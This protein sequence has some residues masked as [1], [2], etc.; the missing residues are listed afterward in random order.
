[1]L[2]SNMRKYVKCL[3]FSKGDKIIY[4][5]I[6]TGYVVSGF[7]KGLL[8]EFYPITTESKNWKRWVTHIVPFTCPHCFSQNGKIYPV[9]Y[10]TGIPVHQN[11]HCETVR[12]IAIEAGTATKD[13]ENGADYWLKHYGKLPD[14]YVDRDV[15]LDAGWRKGKS[16]VKWFPGKMMYG[17]VF[18][19]SS[20]RL[21]NSPGRIWYE[22][23]INYYEGRRNQHRIYYSNDGLIFVTYDHGLTLYEII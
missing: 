11:C 13:G 14:Y 16:P 18:Y 19:N 2:I 21:P 7:I 15:Y 3:K 1:M 23:D 4:I 10:D 9:D 6:V 22:A 20:K 17:G 12:N 8:D 5:K